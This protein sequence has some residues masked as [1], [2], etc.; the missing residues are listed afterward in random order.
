MVN[1][2]YN[3]QRD[4]TQPNPSD[5]VHIKKLK[6]RKKNTQQIDYNHLILTKGRKKN[7]SSSPRIAQSVN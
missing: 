3:P 7:K 1:S 4:K 6:K 5:V 2:I